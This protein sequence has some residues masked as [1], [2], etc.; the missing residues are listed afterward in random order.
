MASGL[1]DQQTTMTAHRMVEAQEL[2]RV[3]WSRTP[4]CSTIRPH[5]RDD[6][7]AA[8]RRPVWRDMMHLATRRPHRPSQGP[9]IDTNVI[10]ARW[11]MAPYLAI[12]QDDSSEL[13]FFRTWP[14]SES[15]ARS[16]FRD[17]TGCKA[18]MHSA[19]AADAKPPP[20]SLLIAGGCRS[21]HAGSQML[22]GIGRSAKVSG[23]NGRSGLM[24]S[25]SSIA[26]IN[27]R[28]C[29]PA[30]QVVRSR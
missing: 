4:R 16:N 13:G 15:P 1:R 21:P 5:R 18:D 29:W 28:V 3:S 12:V 9:E 7:P 27:C 11:L 14:T 2:P 20:A 10:A 24:A 19:A 26:H 22:C 8:I 6:Q 30:C 25:L 23:P 17:V